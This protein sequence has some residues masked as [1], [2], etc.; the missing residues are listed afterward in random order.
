MLAERVTLK[1]MFHRCQGAVETREKFI[2]TSLRDNYD[3]IYFIKQV[4]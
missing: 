4:D 2:Q 3:A 1:K